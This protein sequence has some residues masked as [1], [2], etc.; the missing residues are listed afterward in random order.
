MKVRVQF[1]DKSVVQLLKHA[2]PAFCVLTGRVFENSFSNGEFR[3]VWI[4]LSL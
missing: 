4:S 2:S 3:T 1:H